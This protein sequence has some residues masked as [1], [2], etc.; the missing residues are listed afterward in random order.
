MS[1]DS[2]ARRYYRAIVSVIAGL[3]ATGASLMM[4]ERTNPIDGLFFDL[5]LA[6]TQKR[7]GTDGEPIAVVAL[8]RDSLKADELAPLPRAFLG[9]I[10]ARLLDGLIDAGAKVV[11]F[12]I[13]FEYSA[14][15]LLGS[16]GQYDKSFLTALAQARER[17]V[18]ARSAKAAPALPFAA[19]VLDPGADIEL[20]ADPDGVNRWIA[21]QVQ[22]RE[23]R[24]VPTLAA[25]VLARAQAPPMPSRLL[26][27]PRAALEAIPT[28]RVIEV[29]RCLDRDPE[30]LRRAFADKVVLIGTNLPEEDRRRTP[31]RFM[32]PLLHGPERRIRAR[33][34]AWRLGPG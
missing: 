12:D 17:I 2:L 34:S 31:D 6:A 7:P 28:Y 22:T 27:A 33:S 26:L 10:W 4:G 11:G 29:L 23:G 30:A 16:D 20:F 5:S 32:R 3:L 19:A 18:L 25:A 15:R 13:I 1:R 14:N 9:P 24:S 8:A 21:A